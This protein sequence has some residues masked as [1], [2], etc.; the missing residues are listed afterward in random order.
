M[1]NIGAEMVSAKQVATG[2]FALAL[3][4]SA[5]LVTLSVYTIFIC[6]GKSSEIEVSVKIFLISVIKCAFIKKLTIFYHSFSY[7]N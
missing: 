5:V 6:E 7:L 4:V 3:I 2:S 1:L